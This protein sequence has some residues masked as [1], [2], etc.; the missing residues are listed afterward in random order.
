MVDYALNTAV[1]ISSGVNAL[2]S[3]LPALQPY[4][5]WLCLALLAL[6]TCINLRGVRESARV[7]LPPTALFVLCLGAMLVTGIVKVLLAGGVRRRI[8]CESFSAICEWWRISLCSTIV[9]CRGLR[10]KTTVC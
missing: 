4:A 3:A 7:F 9:C 1:G 2:I 8:I 6:L 10:P 5:L